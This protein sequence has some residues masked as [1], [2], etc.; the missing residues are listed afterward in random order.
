MTHILNKIIFIILL[1]LFLPGVAHGYYPGSSPYSPSTSC[2]K[3]YVYYSYAGCVPDPNNPPPISAPLSEFIF[4]APSS[5]NNG[6]RVYSVRSDTIDNILGGIFNQSGLVKGSVDDLFKGIDKLRRKVGFELKTVIENNRDIDS[7]GSVIAYLDDFQISL[8][9]Q[10]TF[11]TIRMSG[12]SVSASGLKSRKFCPFTCTRVRGGVT[13]NNVI[14]ETTYNFATGSISNS[15]IDFD[16][17]VNLR[18]TGLLGKLNN[19][20]NVIDINESVTNILSDGSG[21]LSNTVDMT[22]IFGINPFLLELRSYFND[23]IVRQGGLP[24][25][26]TVNP[27]EITPFLAGI[28]PQTVF[29]PVNNTE[30][31]NLVDDAVNEAITAV[32]GFGG[33]NIRADFIIQNGR[34]RSNDATGANNGGVRG[35]NRLIV[36]ITNVNR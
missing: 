4:A 24:Q 13:L 27:S 12:L 10:Q 23:F 32:D 5:T 33:L 9:Q 36:V 16:S 22:E 14:I 18:A 1:F 31:L 11:V 15:S 17:V 21:D 30:A 8:T 25:S 34:A 20:F 3:H 7:A 26:I 28:P 19:I 35:P 6:M 29:V 2:P